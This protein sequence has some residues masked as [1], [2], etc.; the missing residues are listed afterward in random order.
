MEDRII[1][2]LLFWL[3][4]LSFPFSA[5]FHFFTLFLIHYRFI[6][7]AALFYFTLCLPEVTTTG[8]RFFNLSHYY[9]YFKFCIVPRENFSHHS[10]VPSLL[11]SFTVVVIFP[12]RQLTTAIAMIFVSTD[13]LPV[14]TILSIMRGRVSLH[15]PICLHD[16]HNTQH[17]CQWFATLIHW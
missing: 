16:P 1:W 5:S 3:F 15:L 7:T 12:S 13:V 17:V 10:P 4:L 8:S 14:P 6:F 11:H 9:Q 2:S